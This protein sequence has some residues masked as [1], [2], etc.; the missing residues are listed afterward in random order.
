M[1]IKKSYKIQDTVWIHGISRFD[2]KL[3]QGTVIHKFNIDDAGYDPETVY[4]VIEIPTAI[5]PL[6]EVRTWHTISQDDQGPVGSLREI[7]EE[8]NPESTKKMLSQTGVNYDLNEDYEFPDIE[9]PTAEQIHAAIE[10]SSKEGVHSALIPKEVKSKP[11]Y[12]S[13]KKKTA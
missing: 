12:R 1:S 2:N 4:Y 11:R 7:Y 6:L 13:R 10:R 9:E 3:T 8:H 5:E